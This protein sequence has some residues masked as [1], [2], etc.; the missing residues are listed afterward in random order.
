[1]FLHFYSMS[2]IFTCTWSDFNFREV[3]GTVVELHVGNKAAKPGMDSTFVSLTPLDL[4]IQ[5]CHEIRLKI[6]PIEMC[7]SHN[8]QLSIQW[9]FSQLSTKAG[10]ETAQGV[11]LHF[12][13]I[14]LFYAHNWCITCSECCQN[15]RDFNTVPGHCI[16]RQLSLCG[17]CSYY[18]T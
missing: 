13:S 14:V 8:F 18:I 6:K 4:Q 12:N 3:K 7:F 16:D 10:H 15:T 1:M 11:Y 9:V 5:W 2:H 17:W